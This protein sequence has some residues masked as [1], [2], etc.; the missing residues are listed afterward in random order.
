MNLLTKYQQGYCREVYDEIRDWGEDAFKSQHYPMVESVLKDTFKR[1]AYN[2]DIIYSELVKLGYCF[3]T[4]IRHDFQRPM[5]K[6]AADV[7]NLLTSLD[8]AVKKKGHVPLSL[9]LFYQMVGSCNF[10]WDYDQRPDIPWEGS[11]PI[12]IAPLTDLLAESAEREDFS[13]LQVSADYWHKDNISGGPP[14]SVK[15]TKHP[16]IDSQFLNEE[17][18]TTFIGYLRLTMENGGF[19]RADKCMH[20]KDFAEF[21]ATVKPKLFKI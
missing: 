7:D 2:L 5:V 8:R 3:P 12:Q 19:S 4:H 10:A 1:L 17:H 18:N 6:P 16:S 13:E 15:L 11:D 9:K 14:Y 20:I 21:Q